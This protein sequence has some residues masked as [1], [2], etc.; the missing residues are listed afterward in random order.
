MDIALPLSCIDGMMSSNVEMAHIFY[1]DL[2][3]TGVLGCLDGQSCFLSSFY[4]F[5]DGPRN[6]GYSERWGKG[7]LPDH[8]K[9]TL[10]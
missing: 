6:W 2:M 3:Q 1:H 7:C 5:L 9:R 10:V 8:E 4:L